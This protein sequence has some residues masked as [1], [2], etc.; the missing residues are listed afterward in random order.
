MTAPKGYPR[1]GHRPP[2]RPNPWGVSPWQAEAIDHLLIEG[3]V[4]AAAKSLGLHHRNAG[5]TINRGLDKIP[6]THRLH[7]LMIWRDFRSLLPSDIPPGSEDSPPFGVTP[8]QARA[9]DLYYEAGKLAPVAHELGL[10]ESSAYSRV[11]HG[12]IKVPGATRGEKRANWVKE[13][14]LQSSQK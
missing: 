3:N 6:G 9:M 4:N 8:K 11:I 1:H 10:S 13:R 2:S 14:R 5:E 7:K 12:E